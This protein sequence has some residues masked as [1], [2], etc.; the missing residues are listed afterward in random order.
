M[1]ASSSSLP[2]SLGKMHIC[3]HFLTTCPETRGAAGSAGS[4]A[5]CRF[6]RWRNPFPMRDP[7]WKLG[8]GKKTC[9]M[10][11]NISQ[12]FP[13]CFLWQIQGFPVAI[14]SHWEIFW[15]SSPQLATESCATLHLKNI[16]MGHDE[17]QT[18]ELQRPMET[19][20]TGHWP[21]KNFETLLIPL[22]FSI[23]STSFQNKS[24]PNTSEGHWVPPRFS[25]DLYRK[26]L[27]S[28]L[29]IGAFAWQG[30]KSPIFQ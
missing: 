9:W 27:S 23:G 6:A 11:H 26:P 28:T 17:L 21:E 8:W 12:I 10:A 5:R 7:F 25:R 30:A 14:L 15:D 4:S 22:I 2:K 16:K 3:I 18:Q 19:M 29:A 1:V 24:I 13:R 20:E